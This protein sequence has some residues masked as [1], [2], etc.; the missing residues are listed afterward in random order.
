MTL[1]KDYNP[2]PK[3]I[4]CGN[5]LIN[6]EIPFEVEGKIPFL[7]GNDGKPKIWL[8]IPSAQSGMLQP[9]IRANR[10]LHKAVNVKGDGTDKLSVSVNGKNIINLTKTSDGIPE[11]DQLD[12]RPIGLNIFG[13]SSTLNIGGHKLSGNTFEN[14]RVMIGIGNNKEKSSNNSVE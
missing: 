11:V 5:T 6:V 13:N 7:V 2:F 12:L 4:I 14:V 10:S 3:I 1:P 9:L 8:N